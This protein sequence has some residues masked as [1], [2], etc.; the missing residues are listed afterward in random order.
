VIGPYQ[1]RA[2]VALSFFHP[3]RDIDG[4]YVAGQAANVTKAMLGPDRLAASGAELAAVT[5]ADHPVAVGWVIVT[6][7]LSRLGEFTLTLSNPAP[8]TA[9]D[10]DE[11]Y[12]IN[13]GAGLAASATLLTSRDRVRTRMQLK[14]AAGLPIQPG[15]AHQ[16]DSLIDLV[17]SEV[18]DEYQQLLG[19]TFIEQP[20]SLYLDGSGNRSLVLP[21]GPI[22]SFTSLSTVDY[23]DDGAGG[24]TEVLTVVPRSTFVVAGLRSQPQFTGLGRL[25]LIGECSRF[26]RGVK[27]YKAV[28]TAGF[29]AVPEGIVGLATED[30]VYRVMTGDKGNLLSQTHGD[31]SITYMRPQQM[32]ELRESRLATY[33]REA[34]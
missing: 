3:V 10:R 15:D 30:V 19:R 8:P 16:L 22:A 6:V 4:N 11:D 23:Q 26:V 33:A 9:D 12:S 27:N 18:S 21:A 34:A 13:V 25:D 31:G 5:L 17:I 24:V 1:A 28:F 14:N 2:G 7:T 32:V 29:A 20:Y